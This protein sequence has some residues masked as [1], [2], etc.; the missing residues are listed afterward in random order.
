MLLGRRDIL[1]EELLQLLTHS[2]RE[3]LLQ[4]AVSSAALLPA[5]LMA[6]RAD[7]DVHETNSG[8]RRL[9]DL[10]LL[11]E[12]L[13]GGLTVPPWLREALL[14]LQA[15]GL[16]GRHDRAWSMHRDKLRSGRWSYDDIVEGCRHL[17]AL[18]LQPDVV[19]YGGS[20]RL[21]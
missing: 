5:D 18:I 12:D 11:S 8:I 6:L 9:I 7:G 10:T 14:P 20:S 3:L 16:P 2:Q 4:A 17:A 19:A 21:R 1:L 13:V 15:E